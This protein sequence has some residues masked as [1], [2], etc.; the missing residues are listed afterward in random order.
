[1]KISENININ[2]DSDRRI[3]WLHI[4]NNDELHYSFETICDYYESL[5]IISSLIKNN[6]IKTV[7]IK[8]ANKKVWSMGGDLELFLKCISTQNIE[9]LN[10]YAH[11][12]VKN[13]HAV[14]NGFDSDVVVISLLQGN[15]FGGG[16]ECALASNYI[17]SEKHVKYSFPESLF[18]TFPGMGAY[19]FL[20]RKIGYSKA[21]KMI[22]S[23]TKWSAN[24]LKDLGIID[25]IIENNSDE[26]LLKLI[27]NNYFLPKD[28][29]S[30]ICN[31]PTLSELLTIVN[32][33][34]KTVMNLDSDKLELIQK[35]VNAQKSIIIKS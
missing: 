13:I 11:K 17:V 16:F 22:N 5:D 19:S 1:M 33:W 26:E 10:E 14:N 34:V 20:T 4:G 7:V 15:A 24:E 29:F 30:M 9:I 2:I 28:K 6:K 18:G 12:C 35:I 31:S 25:I 27:D 21:S 23:S 32:E 8:S 3:L